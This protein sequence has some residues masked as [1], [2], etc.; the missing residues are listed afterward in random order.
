MAEEP[1]AYKVKGDPVLALSKLLDA[2][3]RKNA[4]AAWRGVL[5]RENAVKRALLDILQDTEEV[6]RIFPIIKQQPEY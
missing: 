6:E 2:A 1:T 3:V 5:A 4:P